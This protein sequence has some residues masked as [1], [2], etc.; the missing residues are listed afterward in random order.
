MQKR[1]KIVYKK[2]VADFLQAKCDFT[3]GVQKVRR[4]T[5]LTT[6]YAHP[7]LSPATEM[8]LVQHFSKDL[9]PLQKNCSSWFYVFEPFWET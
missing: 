1:Q 2:N 8:L 6:K 7:I 3:R 9:I 4:L 5:Q